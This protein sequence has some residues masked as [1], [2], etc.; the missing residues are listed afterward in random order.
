MKYAITIA[1]LLFAG[2][3]LVGG[4]TFIT[5]TFTI[6]ETS[7]SLER[8][9]FITSNTTLTRTM[10]FKIVFHYAT[11]FDFLVRDADLLY[12]SMDSQRTSAPD[13]SGIGYTIVFPSGDS[14]NGYYTFVIDLKYTPGNKLKYMAA[15]AAGVTLFSI[16]LT[17]NDQAKLTEAHLVRP[18]PMDEQDSGIAGKM[19]KNDEKLTKIEFAD[20]SGSYKMAFTLTASTGQ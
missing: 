20:N 6:V 7:S 10:D 9:T 8:N 15:S 1:L 16:S 11:I 17:Y 12:K 14:G 4:D 13:T 2:I 3:T 19:I 18:Q 5:N